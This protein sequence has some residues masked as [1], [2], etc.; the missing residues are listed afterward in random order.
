MDCGAARAKGLLFTKIIH[1]KHPNT[2]SSLGIGD[3]LITTIIK[4]GFQKWQL[5]VYCRI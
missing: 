3:G 1:F 2:N 5:D 4:G